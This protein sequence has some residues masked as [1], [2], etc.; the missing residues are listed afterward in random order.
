MKKIETLAEYQQLA[1]RTC[2]DL[3]TPQKNGS[4]MW[5]GF[6]TES[7]EILDVMKKNL[8]YKKD[9]DVVNIGEEVADTMWYIA[10]AANFDGM[11]LP[12]D[13][14]TVGEM[15]V[16]LLEIYKPF[17]DITERTTEVKVNFS[18]KFYKDFL[19]Q[20]HMMTTDEHLVA[21]KFFSDFWEFDFYQLLTNNIEKLQVRYPEK[22]TEEAA[23]NRDLDAE[24]E[25]L[26]K[27]E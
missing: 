1:K 16:G 8:A 21:I 7:G 12:D 17:I 23:L 6:I 2:V 15:W 11:V 22:F 27:N 13:V 5:L 20:A 3:G 14:A 9:V 24:R 19:A 10:N 26:E 4:H 25:V 18:I